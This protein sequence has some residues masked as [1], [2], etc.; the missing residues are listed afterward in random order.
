MP[1]GELRGMRCCCGCCYA[2]QAA[3]TIALGFGPRW[4]RQASPM[5]VEEPLQLAEASTGCPVL[6]QMLGWHSSCGARW[7]GLNDNVQDLP[8]LAWLAHHSL[9]PCEGAS[10]P[11]PGWP[12]EIDAGSGFPGGI[13]GDDGHSSAPRELTKPTVAAADG[14]SAS[15]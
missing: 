7:M 5:V 8:L 3:C 1:I 11:K 13:E 4:L 15:L 14:R 6:R 12:L 2:A 10:P 9:P